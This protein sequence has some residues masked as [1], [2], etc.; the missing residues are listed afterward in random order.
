MHKA[1]EKYTEYMRTV[2]P[3]GTARVDKAGARAEVS[4]SHYVGA[5]ETPLVDRQRLADLDGEEIEALIAEAGP[6]MIAIR[7]WAN[8]TA[9]K[10]EQ[11]FFA[12]PSAQ[13]LSGPQRV[14]QQARRNQP[15]LR[16]LPKE[17]GQTYP[18]DVAE[19]RIVERLL[20]RLEKL[21]DRMESRSRQQAQA[22]PSSELSEKL[23]Q[24][25][26]AKALGDV[27][28]PEAALQRE[29]DR[30]EA[31]RERLAPEEPEDEE[32]SELEDF[33]K[34]QLIAGGV[35]NIAMPALEGIGNQVRSRLGVVSKADLAEAEAELEAMAE[36]ET[37]E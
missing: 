15:R 31:L 30:M 3:L 8:A 17:E 9:A 20:D 37:D 24:T 6:G 28:D 11:F 12:L 26:L 32:D 1:I 33:F 36:A 2:N 19:S 21:E 14:Q 34:G 4:V 7:V 29:L 13:S 35:N 27:I 23:T 22:S 16:L 18:Q 10:P 25:I 5:E